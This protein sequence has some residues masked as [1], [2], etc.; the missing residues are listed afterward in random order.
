[1]EKMV[2]QPMIDYRGQEDSN[3][4][5]KFPDLEKNPKKQ[6]LMP[7]NLLS[8]TE[9][10]PLLSSTTCRFELFPTNFSSGAKW[11]KSSIDR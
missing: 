8:E 10:S 5:G 4:W 11:R 9:T 6:T 1:M 2:D 7:N 3:W